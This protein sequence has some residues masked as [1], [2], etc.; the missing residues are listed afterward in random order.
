MKIKG[1]E[2]ATGNLKV[3]HEKLKY[4][5]RSVSYAGVA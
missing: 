3:W 1:K 4:F 2:L 5:I